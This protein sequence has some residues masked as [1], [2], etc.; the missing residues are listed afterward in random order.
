[1][2]AALM[3]LAKAVQPRSKRSKDLPDF[4]ASDSDPELDDFDLR[5]ALRGSPQG[6]L[7]AIPPAWFA[8][9]KRLLALWKH[10][11]KAR[12]RGSTTLASSSP[13]DWS[14]SW[15]GAGLPPLSKASLVKQHSRSLRGD[16]TRFLTNNYVFWLSHLAAGLVDLPSVT[17]H[18][19]LLLRLRIDHSSEISMDYASW[20]H[21][22][23][24]D[25]L[26]GGS[27]VDLGSRISQLDEALLG[28]ILLRR[29]AGRQQPREH[30]HDEDAPKKPQPRQPQPS[31][32][33]KPGKGSEGPRGKDPKPQPPSK[34]LPPKYI[35]FSHNPAAGLKCPQG[36]KCLKLHLDTSKADL[37]ERWDRAHARFSER[38][39]PRS[40][41]KASE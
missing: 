36:T 24:L 28:R 14:P 18:I 35:C 38:G 12:T 30:P 31:G 1:M 6:T 41:E 15:L 32:Q 27:R 17:A 7:D 5:K 29:S 40:A 19:L 26:K 13:E 34:Q 11:H 21:T 25:S 22:A 16:F 3:A 23:V 8:D 4:Q 33:G 10:A 37:K 20:L 9:G 2:P 39:T